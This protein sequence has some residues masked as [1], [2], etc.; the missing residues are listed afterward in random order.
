[1]LG[2]VYEVHT[3]DTVV[4]RADSE[5][6]GMA[7]AVEVAVHLAEVVLES[8]VEDPPQGSVESAT[9]QNRM[10]SR[11]TARQTR[12]SLAAT[13]MSKMISIMRDRTC[14]SDPA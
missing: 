1:M 2:P 10:T 7:R 4:P 13:R 3:S 5:K 6:V 12:K 14:W 11:L 8:A 9:L